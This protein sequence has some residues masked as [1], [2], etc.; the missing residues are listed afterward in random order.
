[1]FNEF[2]DRKEI[3]EGTLVS[4]NGGQIY[5]I[6][7]A[8]YLGHPGV[9]VLPEIPGLNA[10]PRD[11]P[12]SAPRVPEPEHVNAPQRSMPMPP[13]LSRTVTVE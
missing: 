3:V 4:N 1:M 2:Q 6:D 8:I 9:K 11:I 13:T 10:S 7:D 12:R 5:R